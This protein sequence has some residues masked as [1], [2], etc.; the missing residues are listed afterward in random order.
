MVGTVRRTIYGSLTP[1]DYEGRDGDATHVRA[2]DALHQIAERPPS[3]AVGAY[4]EGQAYIFVTE[5]EFRERSAG[6]CDVP[7]TR[8]GPS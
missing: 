2:G 7:L 4:L 3:E 8:A 5:Q 1:A 6:R